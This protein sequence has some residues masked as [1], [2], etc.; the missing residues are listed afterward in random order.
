MSFSCAP[1]TTGS[2]T[3]FVN[4]KGCG[5]VGDGVTGCTSVS[6]GSSNVF[7]GG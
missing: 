5:R 1:I 2:S 7:A 4:N 3:V 6:T